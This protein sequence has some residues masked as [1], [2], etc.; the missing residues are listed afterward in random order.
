MHIHILGICGTFMAGI[1]SLAKSRG[2]KVTG[3]D[4][5]VYPPMSNQLEEEG[6]SIIEGFDVNQ[7]S[8]KPDI[9]IIGNV[10]TRGNP[11]MESIL[12]NNLPYQSGPEWL[13]ENILRNKWVLA[14]AGTHGKTTTS[15]MLAWILD[16][17]G[18]EPGYLIG[19]IPKN[20]NVSAKDNHK[21]KSNFFVIEADEYDSAFFDK[22]SKFIHYNPRTLVLNNLEFDHADI[23]DS[24]KD[25][26]KQFHHLVKTIPSQG[27]II[28]NKECLNIMN[29]INQ[30]C[31]SEI[32]YF[33]V[34]SEWVYE[35]T[36]SGIEVIHKSLPQGT[37]DWSLL[38]HHN[39]M[40][41]LASIAAAYHVGVLP[42]QSIEALKNF[43]GV[44]RRMEK[45]AEIN[46]VIF[47]D[48]FAHHPTAIKTT[49]DGLKSVANK[50]RRIVVLDPG[51]NTMKLGT[52][53][54]ELKESLFEADQVYIYAGKHINWNL[55]Q[56]FS[57][58]NKT[59][60][61]DDVNDMFN[62]LLENTMKGDHVVFMSNG[63]FSG[64]Q[65]KIIELLQR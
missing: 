17:N 5:N 32:N 33:G 25:I 63:S 55:R 48:D 53:K 19:G 59:F 2:Y 24:L 56:Y 36:N 42:N 22:R 15:A 6:V 47:Y 49:I 57:D 60:V 43:K 50:G 7:I 61:Y 10:I 20:F 38:G 11:L 12:D 34:D 64:V 31:W 9:Y 4:K 44:K 1:A 16:F 27:R 28:A 13:S 58:S 51:S 21:K 37:L 45:L 52:L 35:E 65:K 14:V 3:C 39:A 23:F 26:E 54:L 29:L 62:S 40:N 30:G 18:Y 41:A 46:D 8:L